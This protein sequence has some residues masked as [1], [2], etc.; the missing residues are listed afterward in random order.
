MKKLFCILSLIAACFV[1]STCSSEGN[2]YNPEK[3]RIPGTSYYVQSHNLDD[4]FFI[5]YLI[6]EN[7]WKTGKIQACYNLESFTTTGTITFSG[8][9]ATIAGLSNPATPLNGTW[10]YEYDDEYNVHILRSGSR[11]V[12]FW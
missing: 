1:C 6:L 4:S 2:D 9:K 5:S 8:S 11:Y 7:G 3:M 10:N 12:I